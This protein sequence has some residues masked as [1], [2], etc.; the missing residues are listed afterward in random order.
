MVTAQEFESMLFVAVL[1]DEAFDAEGVQAATFADVGVMSRS[2]GL[3]VRLADGSEFQ[4]TVV[5][6]R[7]SDAEAGR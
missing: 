5:Q 7:L 2:R 6:S 3:V 1:E 4:V